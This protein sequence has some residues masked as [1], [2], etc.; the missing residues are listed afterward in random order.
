MIISFGWTTPALLAG[1]KTV[2]RREWDPDYAQR[3]FEGQLVDAWNTSPRNVRG[4]PRKIA[5]IRLT[6]KPYLEP[7]REAPDEDYEAEG[8]AYFDEIDRKVNGHTPTA[9][10]RAWKQQ[11]PSLWVVRF[12]VVEL[13]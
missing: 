3:F 2:T 5:T 10:W 6:K 7:A 1:R 13:V 9:M 12:E 11:N 4:C 8:F